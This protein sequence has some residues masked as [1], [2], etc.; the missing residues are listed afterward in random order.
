VKYTDPDGR[1]FGLFNTR[2][3]RIKVGRADNGGG[4][5]QYG[6]LL[7][8]AQEYLGL[9]LHQ[10]KLDNLKEVFRKGDKNGIPDVDFDDNYEVIRSDEVVKKASNTPGK[11]GGLNS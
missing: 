4:P 3:S 8:A 9:N 1:N 2:D 10:E 11:A 6:T 7:G 5:C